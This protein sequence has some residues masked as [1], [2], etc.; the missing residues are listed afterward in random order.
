M[1]PSRAEHAEEEGTSAMRTTTSHDAD[2]EA[3]G[4][5]PQPSGRISA[6]IRPLG[7]LP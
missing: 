5:S 7:P 3:Q 6:T 2:Y 1:S 4:A